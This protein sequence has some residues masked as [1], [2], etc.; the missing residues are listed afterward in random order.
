MSKWLPTSRAGLAFLFLFLAL[1]VL[2]FDRYTYLHYAGAEIKV[3]HK[4]VPAAARSTVQARI[5]ELK[6]KLAKTKIGA[7]RYAVAA[8]KNLF[9]PERKAW[10]PPQPK[11]PKTTDKNEKNASPEPPPVRR[12]VVLYG[13]YIAGSTKKAMLYF[14][15][16][17]KGHLRLAEGEE[18]RDAERGSRRPGPVY[19]VVRIDPRKVVL[20]DAR[21][22]EFEVSL[23]DNKKRRPA[24][25]MATKQ[26][27]IRVEKAALHHPTA[28][29]KTGRNHAK[30]QPVGRPGTSGRALT[31]R[32]IRKMS[33]EDKEALVSQGVL[34]KLNTPFGPV[35]RRAK[36]KQ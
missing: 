5:K 4:E 20:K 22:N 11:V 2:F 12:D 3:V 26:P 24:R 15:R 7:G 23:Y 19:T 27:N 14:K 29:S 18:A 10:Q 33:R 21:G 30:A 1:V 32:E 9:S 8:D 34:Q 13:T 17:R 31:A 25:T 6:S 16:F 36:K 28:A 35:Y